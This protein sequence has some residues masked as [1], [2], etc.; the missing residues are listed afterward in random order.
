MQDRLTTSLGAELAGAA[1]EFRHARHRAKLLLDV[2]RGRVAKN[3][4][5]VSVSVS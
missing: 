5:S 1:H 3:S 4:A 2:L